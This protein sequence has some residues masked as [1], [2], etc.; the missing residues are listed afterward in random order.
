MQKIVAKKMAMCK[1]GVLLTTKQSEMLPPFADFEML[2]AKNKLLISYIV[3]SFSKSLN[4]SVFM[5]TDS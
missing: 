1:N 2:I 4:S 3:S 5:I